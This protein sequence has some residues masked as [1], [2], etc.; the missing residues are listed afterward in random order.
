MGPVV[1]F[2]PLDAAARSIGADDVAIRDRT[3]GGRPPT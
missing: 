2:V 1:V 3:G